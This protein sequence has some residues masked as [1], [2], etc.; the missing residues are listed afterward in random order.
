MKARISSAEWEVLNALWGREPMSAS[1]VAAALGDDNAWHPKTV[2][3]FLS[4][5]VAKGVLEVRRGGRPHV[6]ACLLTREECVLEESDS[7]LK[8]VFRGATGPLLAHF[9]EHSEL[10]DRE[11]EELQRLLDQRR[12]SRK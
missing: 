7:F 2:L 6:Y 1:E 5:L 9:V 11:I 4:R 12:S 3:T 10:S 8:R